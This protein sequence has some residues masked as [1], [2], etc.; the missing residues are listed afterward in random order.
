MSDMTISLVIPMYNA[1]RHLRACLES[2]ERQTFR[3]FECLCIDDGSTDSTGAIVREYSARDPRFKLHAQPNAGCSAARNRG[4]RLASAPYLFFLDADDVL[5]PQAFE[6]LHHLSERHGADVSSFQYSRVPD[7][8]ILRDPVRYDLGELPVTVDASP[9]RSFFSGKGKRESAAVWPRLYRKSVVGDILF[10]EG[11][12][13]AED[14]VFVSKVMH[15]IRS[16]AATPVTL[17]FY[18]DNPAS[19]TNSSV[20]ERQI[21]SF[22]QAARMLHD[23]FTCQALSRQEARR[24]S[25]FIS[26]MAYKTCVVPFVRGGCV[27]G[28]DALLKLAHEHWSDLAES[29]AADPSSLTLRKRLIAR[30]FSNNWLAL[31]RRLDALVTRKGR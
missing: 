15:R 18:R 25:V 6:I 29:G 27:Q 10:P 9:F 12:H 21:R 19:A 8:F 11:V 30:C 20:S 22:A 13:F 28:Q 17:L 26:T 16:L 31:A 3:D 4:V 14:L 5:H 7:T 1:A 24:V 2:V 23:Y